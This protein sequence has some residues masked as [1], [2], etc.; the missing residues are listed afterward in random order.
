[1]NE[2]QEK[3]LEVIELHHARN[4]KLLQLIASGT[5]INEIAREFGISKS[6]AH[7]IVTERYWKSI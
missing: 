1:M 2:S 4:K 7:V 6:Q 3:Q 5:K